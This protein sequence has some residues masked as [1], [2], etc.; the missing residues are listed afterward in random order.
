MKFSNKTK[1]FTGD[2]DAGL[3]DLDDDG[4]LGNKKKTTLSAAD[5]GK[6]FV[7]LGSTAQARGPHKDDEE[8]K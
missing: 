7:N 4:N 6:E 2:F 3:D 1:N 5:G 8:E